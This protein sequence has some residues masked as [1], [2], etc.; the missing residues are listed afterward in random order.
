MDEN[1]GN[2]DGGEGKG[3]IEA[4]ADHTKKNAVQA[5]HA[6][7]KRAAFNCTDEAKRKA[8]SHAE[9]TQDDEARV[10]TSCG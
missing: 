9:T 3:R 4:A 8:L 1:S 6:V 10:R 5:G 2:A 7:T